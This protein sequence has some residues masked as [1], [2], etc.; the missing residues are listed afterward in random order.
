[1]IATFIILTSLIALLPGLM[2]VDGILASGVVSAI[3]AIAMVTVVLMLHTRDLDRFSRL[4]RPPSFIVLFIP[5]LWMLLQVPP[6]PARS[7]ANPVWVSASTALGKPFVGAVSLDIGATLLSLAR[8]CAILA[9]AR[10]DSAPLSG[11]PG[12]GERIHGFGQA[13]RWCRKFGYRRNVAF[14]RPL[15]RHSGRRLRY[16]HCHAQQAVR[17]KR[18]MRADGYR[19]ADC[20]RTDRIRTGSSAF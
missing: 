2:M 3:V 7:L 11:Y 12:L 15:L 1:M 13:V 8:Y 16:R 10:S 19:H 4:L 14:S 17:G 6:I 9:A 18:S 5:C 20:S